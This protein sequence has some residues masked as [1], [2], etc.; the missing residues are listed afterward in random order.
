MEA[1][2]R[3]RGVAWAVITVLGC[4]LCYSLGFQSGW[5][6]AAQSAAGRLDGITEALEEMRLSTLEPGPAGGAQT[7][8]DVTGMP[9]G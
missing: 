4:G 9:S 8:G 2:I 1:G 6:G 3:A 5:A 7:G